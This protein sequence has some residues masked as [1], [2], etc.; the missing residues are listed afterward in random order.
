MADVK[1]KRNASAYTNEIQFIRCE[2]DFANDAGAQ[3]EFVL[4]DVKQDMM[5]LSARTSVTTTFTGASSAYI[6]GIT[7]DTDAILASTAVGSMTAGTVFDG[8]SAS[9]NTPVSDGDTISMTI[10][11]ADATA[12]KLEVI[13]EMAKR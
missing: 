1:R 8:A 6:V 3:G 5:I 2:Y 11:T 12:G 7:G 13:L 9:T 4:C 10:G